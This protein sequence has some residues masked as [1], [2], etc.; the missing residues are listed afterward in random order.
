M[1]CLVVLLFVLMSFQV[2]AEEQYLVPIK[3]SQRLS[4]EA[5]RAY[6]NYETVCVQENCYYVVDKETAEQMVKDG[7]ADSYEPTVERHLFNK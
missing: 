2:V 3:N 1:K 5:S 6:T 4:V 7:M